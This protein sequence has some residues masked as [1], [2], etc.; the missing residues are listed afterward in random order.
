[1]DGYAEG[2]LGDTMHTYFFDYTVNDAYTCTSPAANCV[3]CSFN[4]ICMT[5]I[6]VEI[7]NSLIIILL[8]IM[9]RKR[10]GKQRQNGGKYFS[11]PFF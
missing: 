3:S 6:K 5:W 1:M 4:P 10:V 9:Q 7:F 2:R 8:P 11:D